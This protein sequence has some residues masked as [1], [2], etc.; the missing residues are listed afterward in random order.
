MKFYGRIPGGKRNKLL[1]C[2]GDLDNHADCSVGNLGYFALPNP[3]SCSVMNKI[4]LNQI[5]PL[6]KKLSGFL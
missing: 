3:F 4:C 2:D 1:N 5:W 6:P